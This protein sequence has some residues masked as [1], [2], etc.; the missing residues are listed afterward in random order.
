MLDHY[1][2]EGKPTNSGSWTRE[3]YFS[4]TSAHPAQGIILLDQ[5]LSNPLIYGLTNSYSQTFTDWDERDTEHVLGIVCDAWNCE[6]NAYGYSL[7][8][9]D[10]RIDYPEGEVSKSAWDD[11]PS[12]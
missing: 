9:Y 1:E 4:K 12:P 6:S 5:S 8:H 2:F 7:A 3:G 11:N 10:S